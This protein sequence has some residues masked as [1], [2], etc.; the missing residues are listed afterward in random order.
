MFIPSM[1]CTTLRDPLRLG[2]PRYMAEP[3]CDGQRAQIHVADEFDPTK[4][5]DAF[6][7]RLEQAAH[8]KA[9]GQTLDIAEPAPARAPVIDLMEALQESVRKPPAK[10]RAREAVA[11]PAPPVARARKGRKSGAA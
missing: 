10:A 9:T 2:D 11:A 6:R 8:E 5:H 3:R 7:E 4:Y 1:L